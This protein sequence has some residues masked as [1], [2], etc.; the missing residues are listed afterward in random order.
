MTDRRFWPA[1]GRVAHESLAARVKGVDL[2]DGQ[3]R[4]IGVPVADLFA[5]PGGARDKQ[6]LFGHAFNVLEERNGWAFGFDVVDNYVGY[7]RSDHLH[8]MP[9]STHRVIARSSHIYTLDDIKSPDRT[10]LSHFSELAVVAET[11]EFVELTTGGFVPVQHVAPLSWRAE[12]PATEAERY[13]GT[14]YLWGGNSAWGIDCSG[15]V[16]TAFY[17]AGRACPRDSDLQAKAWSDA[18]GPLQRG[19]LVFWKGH[20]GMMLDDTRLLH[21]NAFHMAVAVEPLDRARER[22]AAKDF[23]EITRMARP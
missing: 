21:A 5:A 14:P 15:L 2:T 7:L 4:R 22:I 17:A 13:L 10:P 18:E 1:N 20:V 12:D 9:E 6:M 11:D 8:D 3:I 16:Q 23:G 19:D